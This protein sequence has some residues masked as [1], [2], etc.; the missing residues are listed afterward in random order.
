MGDNPMPDACM[1][2]DQATTH[3]PIDTSSQFD[4]HRLMSYVPSIRNRNLDYGLL[5]EEPS[6]EKVC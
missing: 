5:L 2:I 6:N 1:R 3:F 4:D